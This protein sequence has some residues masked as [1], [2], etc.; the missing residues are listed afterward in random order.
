MILDR[1]I[2]QKLREEKKRLLS[3]EQMKKQFLRSKSDWSLLEKLVQQINLQPELK[4]EVHLNDGTVL[5]LRCYDENEN[6]ID[7]GSILPVFED[8]PAIKIRKMAKH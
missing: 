1:E 8:D 7:D 6:K 5:Y 4:I 2:K 3:E